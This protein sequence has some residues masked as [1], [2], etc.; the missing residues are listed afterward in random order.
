MPGRR[1]LDGALHQGHMR[2]AIP[3]STFKTLSG[4]GLHADDDPNSSAEE[5]L[6]NEIM[7]DYFFGVPILVCLKPNRTCIPAARFFAP[8]F[9]GGN[10]KANLQDRLHGLQ[11]AKGEWGS[12][13]SCFL[14][15]E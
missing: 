3:N 8:C 6:A 9:R 7:D 4:L 12:Q 13:G 2:L 10:S 15:L 11:S 5:E 14:F 1:D